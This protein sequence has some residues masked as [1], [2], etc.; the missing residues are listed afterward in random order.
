MSHI[1]PRAPE[2]PPEKTPLNDET[3]AGRI[4]SLRESDDKL[5]REQAVGLVLN[6]EGTVQDFYRIWAEIEAEKKAMEGVPLQAEGN[7]MEAISSVGNHLDPVQWII[8]MRA[9]LGVAEIVAPAEPV[10]L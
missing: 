2:T 8:G 10:K 1:Y 7:Y 5:T 3:I 4:V 6:G 9:K